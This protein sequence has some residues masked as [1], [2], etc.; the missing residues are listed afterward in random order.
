M[1][2]VENVF[3][4]PW[5]ARVA[6]GLTLIPGVPLGRSGR[7]R[8]YTQALTAYRVFDVVVWSRFASRRRG[9]PRP[10]LLLLPG[11]HALVVGELFAGLLTAPGF[12][13]CGFIGARVAL[14]ALRTELD[15]LSHHHDL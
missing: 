15:A 12:R 7:F 6:D 5:F 3:G 11:A 14:A 2:P 13:L 9:T 4:G 10:L 1:G 8:A